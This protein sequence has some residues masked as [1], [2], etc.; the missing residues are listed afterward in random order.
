MTN[1]TTANRA[2]VIGAHPDD[3][4]FGA[5]G[6]IAKLAQ[7]GCEITYIIC[8]NGNKGSHDP[9]MTSYRLAEVREVEQRTAAAR[10][11][12]QQVIFLRYNDG[13]MEPTPALRAEMALYIRHFKPTIV[14]THDPWKHYMLHPDHRAVGFAVIEGI[15]SARDHLYMP[16]L[17]Q[18][19]LTVWR[20]QFLY[21]WSAEQ[22]DHTEDISETLELKIAAL[23]E[24]HTQLDG[25]T[26]LEERMRQ[27][28]AEAGQP[29]GFAAGESFRRMSL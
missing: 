21:L 2:L 16:G 17:G 11:G 8:T 13:E 4:E 6:T 7:Q 26:D 24:H 12:V 9:D 20:P 1:E 15:V 19:G 29:A 23:R 14:F 25:M 5:G 27:R 22:P 18:I 10:L 28:A 3:N